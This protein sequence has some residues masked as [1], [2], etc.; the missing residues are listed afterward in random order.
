[1]QKA[2]DIKGLSLVI[3]TVPCSSEKVVN[4][5]I[6]RLRKL[7]NKEVFFVDMYDE[8]FSAQRN[9]ASKRLRLYKKKAKQILKIK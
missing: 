6:G 1:M 2:I 3:N 4:Q 7:D 9:Q 5:M 8:G